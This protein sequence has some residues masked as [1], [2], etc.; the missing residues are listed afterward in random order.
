MQPVM[1]LTLERCHQASL[2][3]CLAAML[4]C[5]SQGLARSHYLPSVQ[6]AVTAVVRAAES[7][8]ARA[9]VQ[10]EAIRDAAHLF[11]AAGVSAPAGPGAATQ[12]R[13]EPVLPIAETIATQTGGF[14]PSSKWFCL[15]SWHAPLLARESGA[16][17]CADQSLLQPL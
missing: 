17:A 2:V 8:L 5:W 9:R 15:S 11:L 3:A 16:P 7:T 4:F 12:R 1:R 14:F 13:V 10:L 6:N